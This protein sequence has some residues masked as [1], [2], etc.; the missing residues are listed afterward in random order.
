MCAR[1]LV[2]ALAAAAL[3]FASACGSRPEAT[4]PDAAVSVVATTT[5]VGAL[6]RAVG[7][8]RAVLHQ[9]LQPNSDPHEYE[10]RPSDARALD[11]ADLVFRS[12]GEIDAWAS[13]LTRGDASGR[14][15][16]LSESVR[17]RGNDPHW[18]QDPRNAVLAVAAIRGALVRAD[19]SG[20][21]TYDRN[22]RS[23]TVALKRLDRS[24]AACVDQLPRAQRKLVTSHDAL[25][26]FVARYRLKLVGTVVPSLSTRAQPSSKDINRLVAQIRA[27]GVRAIFPESS[28]SPKL[29]RAV[30]RETGASVGGALRADAL[31]PA[32]SS[33]ATYIGSIEANTRAI[34]RGLSG[35]AIACPLR[36]PARG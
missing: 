34:V 19:P 27:E 14:T 29:E 7:G 24:V 9:I 15:V 17:L 5:Q 30:A 31:G 4:D 18:W 10:P 25:G 3:V 20:R 2:F 26:Y 23:Y 16:T 28:L 22:A 33:G 35:G 6:V 11:A 32:G 12:G 13:D 21:A 1:T 8:R 36:R